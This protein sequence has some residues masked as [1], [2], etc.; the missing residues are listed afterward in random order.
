MYKQCTDHGHTIYF[1]SMR[2]CGVRIRKRVFRGCRRCYN[3]GR[4]T[5]NAECAFADTLKLEQLHTSGGT[6]WH[7]H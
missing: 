7:T 2:V 3:G 5:I 4:V 6:N 1:A